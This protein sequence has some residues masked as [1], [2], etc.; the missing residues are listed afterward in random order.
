MKIGNGN[1]FWCLNKQKAGDFLEVGTTKIIFWYALTGHIGESGILISGTTK[2]RSP[3]CIVFDHDM[4]IKRISF[5]LLISMLLLHNCLFGLTVFT[6]LG[7]KLLVL[8]IKKNACKNK[9]Q[10]V[11]SQASF[12]SSSL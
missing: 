3:N 11:A 6:E 10:N 5:S 7:T 2:F 12:T 1:T 8:L 9:H 4:L